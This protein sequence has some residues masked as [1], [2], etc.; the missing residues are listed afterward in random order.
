[1]NI[2][3]IFTIALLGLLMLSSLIV[4]G[5]ITAR[6]NVV[7]P[8]LE[9]HDRNPVPISPGIVIACGLA[10]I[11]AQRIAFSAFEVQEATSLAN[12]HYA[13]LAN[14]LTVFFVVAILLVSYGFGALRDLG[15]FPRDPFSEIASGIWGF[16]ASILP[17][18]AVI[19]ATSHFRSESQQ[20]SFLQFLR[21][22]PSPEVILWIGLAVCVL[23]PLAEELLFRVV[24]QG[25]MQARMEPRTAILIASVIFAAVHNLP[26]SIALLPLGG[27]LGYVYY[28]RNSYL[29]AVVVHALFN[30]IN[31]EMLLL[32]LRQQ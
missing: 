13:S 25:A 12:V 19:I 28:Q 27:I 14:L 24:L 16:L 32:S 22:N 4:W 17:V 15:L 8:A 10:W 11:L 30:L 7:Q 20:H 21:A 29:A 1:M 3:D 23:A 18:L 2:L 31:L 5:V 9:Q 6:W 26:D